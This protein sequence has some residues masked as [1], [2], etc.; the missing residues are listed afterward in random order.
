[1][2]NEQKLMEEAGVRYSFSRPD[3]DIGFTE[4]NYKWSHHPTIQ[5]GKRTVFVLG[6]TNELLA[7]LNHWNRNANGWTYWW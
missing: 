6:G 1:M 4:F 3:K 5:D 7:L 2:D